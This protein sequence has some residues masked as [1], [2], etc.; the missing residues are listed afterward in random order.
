[1][2]VLPVLLELPVCVADRGQPEAKAAQLHMVAGAIEEAT[3]DPSERAAL[4]TIAWFESR[5]C[6]RVHAGE[7]RGGLGEGL[8][9]LEPGSRRRPPFAGLGSSETA[10][11]AGEALALWRLGRCA[12]RPL[13]A[14]FRAYA[15][16]GCGPRDWAGAE[17]R[18]RFMRWTLGALRRPEPSWVGR[19]VAAFWPAPYVGND[20]TVEG[21]TAY[22]NGHSYVCPSPQYG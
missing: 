8:W 3:A 18:A 20:Q 2:L 11:A 13:A 15:G 4:I 6:L 16:L 12:G 14:R 10:H 1:M 22:R 19:A 7:L 17:P 9:Q 5:L 21:S